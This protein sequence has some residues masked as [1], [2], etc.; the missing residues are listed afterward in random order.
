MSPSVRSILVAS[1]IAGLPLQSL[2]A[3]PKAS[4]FYE[5]ALARYEKRDMAGAVIQLKNALQID[6]SMLAAHVLLGKAL[7]A[8]GDIPAAEAAF[9]EALRLGV[10]RAEVIVPLGHLYLLQGKYE[11]VL[12]RITI[13]GLPPATQAE[14]LVLQANAHNE[15]GNRHAAVKALEEARATDPSSVMVRLAQAAYYIRSNDLAR[16]TT[17]TDEAIALS[18]NNAGAWNTR[19]SLLHLKGDIPGALAAYVKSAGLDPSYLEPRIARASLLIDVGR[20]DEADREVSELE[21]TA[22][23]EPRVNYLRALIAAGRN[24]AAGVKNALT[25]ITKTLDGAPTVLL[26]A[27]R[28]MLFLAAMAHFGLG[29]Q[30]KAIDRL[31]V[32]LRQYPGEPGPTKLLASI[33]LDRGDRTRVISLLEPL[34]RAYPADHRAMM[35]LAGAYMQDRNFRQASALLDQAV[36]ASGGASDI[37]T[38]FGLSLVGAGKTDLGI[39]QL[40]QTLAKDPKQARAGLSLAT[41]LLRKGQPKRALDVIE[42]LVANDPGNLTALNLAGVV[43]VAAGN[44]AGGRKAYEQVLAKDPGHQAAVLNLS[45]LDLVEGKADN[46]RQRLT[47]FL[48]SDPANVDAMIELATVEERSG[49]MNDAVRWLEKARAEPKGALRAGIQ[50][51]DLH[52]RGKNSDQANAAA[53]ELLT[54]FPDNLAALDTMT[55]T[56]LA[57]GDAR[58]ARQTLGEMTRY[59]NYDHDAQLQV[60]RLQMAAGNPAGAGYSVEKALSS[61][62][63]SLAAQ[64]LYTEVNIAQRDFPKA[65]QRI[66]TIAEKYPNSSAAQRLQGDLAIAR[67]QHAVAVSSYAAAIKRDNSPEVALRLFQAHYGAGE[68]GKGIAFLD[69]WQRD[70]PGHTAVMRT[71]ADAQLRSGNLHAARSGYE[72]LH[73]LQP[74]NADVLNNLAQTAFKQNDKTAS[75]YAEKAVALRPGDP[76]IIDTLGW[77]LVRQGQLERGLAMLRDARL[78]NPGDPEIRYHLASALSQSGRKSEAKD[79]LSQALKAGIPFEGLDDARRLEK[80]LNK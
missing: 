64:I 8:G 51:T 4:R 42:K 76:G 69:K 20:T 7:Q 67:G 74:D 34:L 70:N 55:R 65:E 68:L 6:R 71:L 73:K 43:R 79:E 13:A 19:A 11:T 63:D 53:R 1:L 41:V 59:A 14:V 30:E 37:R 57:Q 72:Q 3:D 75:G 56:Q 15:R 32:Y 33:Y 66:R 2:A 25:E 18:P 78:R 38:E 31:A 52:L 12:E 36:K 9:E 40:E 44:P 10:N 17:L 61:R 5:D 21:K 24:D 46:A 45:R 49:R 23:E 39:E 50:L 58:G 62:P 54:K 60:A 29:N 77:I 16:A 80:E 22:P 47:Q 48:K 35:L 27:N 28:Q 26:N